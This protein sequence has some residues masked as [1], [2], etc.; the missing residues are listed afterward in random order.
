MS[1]GADLLDRIAKHISRFIVFKSDA[2][3]VL[4]DHPDAAGELVRFADFLQEMNR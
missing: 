1:A 2:H 4:V 3:H